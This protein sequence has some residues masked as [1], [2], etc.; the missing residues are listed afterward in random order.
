[1][2][3]TTETLA[4]R[5]RHLL[6][7]ESDRDAPSPRGSRD[8]PALGSYLTALGAAG[9]ETTLAADDY[10]Q[11]PA[12]VAVEWQY[13]QCLRGHRRVQ[14]GLGPGEANRALDKLRER[15]V[16]NAAPR[17]HPDS[18]CHQSLRPAQELR[19]QTRRTSHGS[20][21]GQY[22]PGRC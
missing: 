10:S 7:G 4:A 13:R 20:P 21:D 14:Y 6:Q 19:P 18:E 2:K 12:D 16:E 15:L 9:D 1:M 11:R 17:Q 5:H 3:K 22:L 8:F